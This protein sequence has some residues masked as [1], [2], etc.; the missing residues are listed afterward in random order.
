[1]QSQQIVEAD[2]AVG[3]PDHSHQPSTERKEEDH[4]WI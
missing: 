3:T 2:R 1:M 4:A